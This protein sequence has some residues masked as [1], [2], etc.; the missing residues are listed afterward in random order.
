MVRVLHVD[1]LR[2]QTLTTA[3]SDRPS[4]SDKGLTTE[5]YPD[6]LRVVVYER[7]PFMFVFLFELHSDSLTMPALYRSIHHQLGPL[8]RPLLNSTSPERVSDRLSEAALPRSTAS[9]KSAQ[10]ISDLVYDPLRLTVHS[11]IPNIP[12]PGTAGAEG[13]KDVE[14]KWSRVEALNVHTQILNTYSS[15]RRAKAE[16]ERTCKTGRG[17]WVVWM[18]LPQ[19]SDPKNASLYRE[20]FLIRKASDYTPPAARKASSRFGRDV[21]RSNPG[22]GWGPGKLAEGIGIDARQYIDGLLSLN[23]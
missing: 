2:S 16:L 3:T 22:A 17:W 7:Q 21:R 23:R 1:R 18:R 6:R 8:Q 10:P 15:T 19:S 14:A 11:S 20:A 4:D 9:I 13:L 12:E 5:S